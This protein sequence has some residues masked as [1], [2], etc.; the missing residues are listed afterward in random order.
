[1]GVPTAKFGK[2]DLEAE[3]LGHLGEIKIERSEYDNLFVVT[4]QGE[5]VPIVLHLHY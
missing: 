3:A 4:S 2:R 1:V 5:Q